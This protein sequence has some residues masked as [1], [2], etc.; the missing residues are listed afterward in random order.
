MEVGMVDTEG[1][2]G[3]GTEARRTLFTRLSTPSTTTCTRPTLL[4]RRTSK[5]VSTTLTLHKR[6]NT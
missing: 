1:M 2:E 3:T 5:L 6:P 4:A